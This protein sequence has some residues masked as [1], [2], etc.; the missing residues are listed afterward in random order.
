MSDLTWLSAFAIGL[1]GGVHCVGMCGGIVG[2]LT[3]GMPQR[4][5][6]GWQAWR[7]HL[8]YNTGRIAS[9]VIAGALVG[10]LGFYIASTASVQYAQQSLLVLA[11][12]FMIFLGLYLAQW[13]QLLSK[14]EKLGGVV[15]KKIQPLG[16]GLLPVQRPQQALLLGML[17]G[18]LPCGL[19]YSVLIWA[20]S[21]GGA[22]EG[23]L[24]MLG[25][26]LGT[27]PNLLLMGAAANW[28][29]QFVRQNSVR[30]IAGSLVSLYGFFMLYRAFAIT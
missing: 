21:S 1:L 7:F 5:N 4:N 18:W 15:W 12:V 20:I 19:V 22:S 13:S 28:L 8:A 17:W 2:A 27:L 30:K 23:A 29:Q 9:Y 11:A 24:L 25:F 3:M 6:T 14:V 16:N 10:A 26:G